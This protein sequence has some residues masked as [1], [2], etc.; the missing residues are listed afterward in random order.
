MYFTAPHP[1]LNINAGLRSIAGLRL[2]WL[3]AWPANGVGETEASFPTALGYKQASRDKMGDV[4][5]GN[6]L[7]ILQLLH[8][9]NSSNKDGTV[10]IPYRIMLSTEPVHYTL[11]SSH[12]ICGHT[13]CKVLHYTMYFQRCSTAN[14]RYTGKPATA[15]RWTRRRPGHDGHNLLTQTSLH[16][17]SPG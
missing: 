15:A 14:D 8:I 9:T 6:Y 16:I 2:L 13:L 11:H 3:V 12:L 10:C 7:F 17:Q 5:M 1:Y 4:T